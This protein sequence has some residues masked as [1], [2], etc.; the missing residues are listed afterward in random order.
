M[1][2]AQEFLPYCYEAKE[3]RR[4]ENSDSAYAAALQDRLN[5]VRAEVELQAKV[6]QSLKRELD[7]VESQAKQKHEELRELRHDWAKEQISREALLRETGET[8]RS[9]ALKERRCAE[10][11]AKHVAAELPGGA[12]KA[13]TGAEKS[14]TSRR[15]ASLEEKRVELSAGLQ[16]LTDAVRQ[17]LGLINQLTSRSEV[18]RRE[19]RALRTGSEAAKEGEARV[20]RKMEDVSA[21][22]LAALQREQL[23][24]R[25]SLD[26]K[27]HVRQLRGQLEAVQAPAVNGMDQVAF[28]LN[29]KLEAKVD[30]LRKELEREK[31]KYGELEMSVEGPQASQPD[32]RTN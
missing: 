6:A 30:F 3:G 13:R 10:T 8:E 1:Q 23:L 29:K 4:E 9:L 26:L 32:S 31:A 14:E 11:L 5:K 17:E 16:E 21:A 19:A 18:L 20:W 24:Q 2:G 7:E 27:E 22:E 28:E 25:Q 15:L 12:R